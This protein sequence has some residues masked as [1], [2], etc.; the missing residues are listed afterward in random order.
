MT[1]KMTIHTMS[2][3]CQYSPAIST[4]SELLGRE[5]ALHRAG[6]TATAAR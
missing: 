5:L 3:K 2:T 4:A 1:V 6:P